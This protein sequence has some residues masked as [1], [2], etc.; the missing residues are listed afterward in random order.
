MVI[1]GGS[2]YHGSRKVY[3]L[4]SGT[5]NLDL[6]YAIVEELKKQNR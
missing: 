6:D 1:T 5:G 2:D 3:G 4:G